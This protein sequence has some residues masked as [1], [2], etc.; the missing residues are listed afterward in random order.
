MVLLEYE[1]GM[2][3]AVDIE[4][5]RARY[6]GNHSTNRELSDLRNAIR[7]NTTLQQELEEAHRCD[8]HLYG[9]A[10]ARFC[11]RLADTN[12][13]GSGV[14]QSS[15]GQSGICKP[16]FANTPAWGRW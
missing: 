16:G 9:V 7:E 4:V 11:S 12:L 6:S 13:L 8:I 2:P 3:P 14:V 10:V 5:N 15:L 1:F